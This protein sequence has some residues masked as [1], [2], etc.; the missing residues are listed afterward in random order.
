M[1]AVKAT[2]FVELVEKKEKLE[3]EKDLL[4]QFRTRKQ[5]ILEVV[6]MFTVVS[7]SLQVMRSAGITC[8]DYTQIVAQATAMVE[9]KLKLFTEKPEWILDTTEFQSFQ[10]TMKSIVD[11]IQKTLLE[12]W[13]VYVL[14]LIP[15]IQKETLGI[16]KNISSFRDD[17]SKMEQHLQT[18]QELSSRLPSQPTDI[19]QLQEQ[20]DD[21]HK[22]W[23]KFGQGNVPDTVL[24]FLKLAGSSSGAPI[25]LWTSEV[26]TWLNEQGITNRCTIRI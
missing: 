18:V 8:P 5:Q 16:F 10:K 22:I 1:L 26:I 4:K 2:R 21:L 12:V 24:T 9:N 23:S 3:K 14:S 20:C 6:A 19:K 11:S 25:A 17:I 7:S 13:K 15:H